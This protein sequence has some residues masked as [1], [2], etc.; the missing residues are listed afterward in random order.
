MARP[1]PRLV[2]ASA[3]PFRRRLLR[4][5]GLSF[6]V[7]A[8]DVDEAAVKAR[9]AHCRPEAIAELLAAMKAEAVGARLPERLVI[10]A[11]QVLSCGQELLSKPANAH[12]ARAQL[13]RL[14]GRRH[15]LYTAVALVSG[16]KRVWSQV[17]KATLVM[18]AFSDR[19]L[20]AYLQEVG[21]RALQTVGAYEVEG[22]GIQLFERIEGD[23]FTIVGLPLLSLLAELRR[24]GAL[25]T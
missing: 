18:R 22:R 5:A 16:G 21:A 24:R 11:D 1:V 10:G 7:V 17:E 14:R 15:C 23:H 4:A 6:Q 12:E 9:A 2:L 8:A 20:A 13:R 19:F 3:S 25:P